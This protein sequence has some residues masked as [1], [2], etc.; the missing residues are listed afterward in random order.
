MMAT[1]MVIKDSKNFLKKWITEE[2]MTVKIEAPNAAKLA[3]F[4]KKHASAGNAL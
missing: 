2:A 1:M 3:T 4:L